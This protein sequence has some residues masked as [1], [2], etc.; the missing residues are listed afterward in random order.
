[1][2]CWLACCAEQ[3]YDVNVQLLVQHIISMPSRMAAS[4]AHHARRGT[5]ILFSKCLN[6]PG[7]VPKWEQT[8][9]PSRWSWVRTPGKAPG[10]FWFTWGN[11]SV[12]GHP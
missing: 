7:V 9:I 3:A 4:Q 12:G 10:I 2:S 6:Q 5:C 11:S 8:Q 1:M